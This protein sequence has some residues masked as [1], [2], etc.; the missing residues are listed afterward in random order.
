MNNDDIW[1]TGSIPFTKVN[2]NGKVIRIER[3]I[4]TV[5][6][7]GKEY[8]RISPEQEIQPSDNGTGYF[9]IRIIIDNI[10]YRKYVH[11]LVWESFKG[12]IPTGYE[13]DHIDNVKS[14]NSLSNLQLLTRKENMAKM[15]LNNPR[16][17]KNL[18]NG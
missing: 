6:K 4:N 1:I 3:Y 2:Y 17:K 18:I 8:T 7:L 12:K 14:N 11:V 5:S 9:Q 16:V 15:L 10:T 13:I